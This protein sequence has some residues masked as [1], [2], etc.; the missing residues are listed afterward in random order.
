MDVASYIVLTPIL[1]AFA[2]LCTAAEVAFF[3]L[4]RD[5]I[6]R[7]KKTGG[8]AS[9][10][11]LFLLDQPRELLLTTVFGQ[12][13][14]IIGL[15]GCTMGLANSF[16]EASNT[17]LFYTGIVSLVLLAVIYLLLGVLIPRLMAT[18]NP[19][20]TL[21]TVA[22]PL[23]L[24]Y[25]VLMPVTAPFALLSRGIARILGIERERPAMSDSQ[26]NALIEID[27]EHGE[28]NESEREMIKAVIEFR[29]TAA[30]EIMVP[31][32]DVVALSVDLPIEAAIRKVRESGHSRIPI[33]D[34]TIDKILGILYAK[35]MLGTTPPGTTLRNLARP[36]YYVPENK[37]VDELLKEFQ[38]RRLHLAVV[39][40]EYGGTAGVVTLEDILEEI[41]GEI[42]DEY[43]KEAVALQRLGEDSWLAEGRCQVFDINEQLGDTAVPEGE[44]YDTL[45]G[46]LYAV[47]GRVPDP[48]ETFRQ[49]NW[50]YTV[51]KRAG[52][53]IV[54]VRL[55]RD[56]SPVEEAYVGH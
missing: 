40:D 10:R 37:H 46:F 53:R 9:E 45:G 36:V 1:F 39:V 22:L 3:A 47:A 26:L 13:L 19:E 20:R 17:S 35:D 51:E 15:T 34:G 31:R 56:D 4:E 14:A 42:Q 52:N 30:R 11:I 32:I 49:G 6:E 8:G 2:F 29:D 55:Q 24:I 23:K 5:E 54:A 43:D 21:R 16:A 12:V 48:G 27:E 7:I 18:G 50:S 44:D 41:I 25:Y 38:H 28:I 33:F